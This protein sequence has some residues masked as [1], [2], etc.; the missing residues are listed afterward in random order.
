MTQLASTV[1]YL[2]SLM[3][4]VNVFKDTFRF[5]HVHNH[6]ENRTFYYRLYICNMDET[7]YFF[8]CSVL[9]EM[10]IKIRE[11]LLLW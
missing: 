8:R 11:R 10:V 5:Y 4:R 1:A 2:F 3:V 9:F 6:Q 7:P